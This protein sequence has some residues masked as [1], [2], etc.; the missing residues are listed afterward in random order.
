MSAASRRHSPGAIL[1]FVRY[2]AASSGRRFAIA[3]A[4]LV[5]G[6]LTEGVSILLVIPLLSLA[7]GNPGAG[8]ALP[9][10]MPGNLTL[11]LPEAL[12]GLVVLIALQGLFTRSKNIYLADLLFDLLN[13]LRLD[14]FAAIGALRWDALVR[15]RPSDLHHLLTGDVERVYT[16]AMAVMMLLQTA[17]LLVIYLAVAWI[18]S[19]VM[20]L[21][22]AALGLLILALLTPL[23]A[24]A[25]RFG[26]TRTANKRDQY[27][28]VSEYLG[29]LKT[30][31]IH[32]A[33]GAY[34]ARLAANLD[35]VHA[36]AVGYMRLISLGTILSQVVSAL[37]VAVL[38]YA[39]ISLLGMALP[40]LV[41][42]L[43]L[44]MRIAPRFTAMQT[45]L[46]QLLGEVTVFA[47]IQ[48]FRA[49]CAAEAEPPPPPPLALP[50]RLRDAI[51]LA[52]VRYA[53]EGGDARPAITD[54]DLSIP[55]G[56]ITA[57]VGPSGSG[58][59]TTADLVCG[60]L[61]PQAGTIHIDACALTPERARLW[62]RAIAYVPQEHFLIPG[63]IAANLRLARP[64]AGEGEMWRALERAGAADFVRALSHG[65]D[66]VLG[67]NG[68]RLSGGQRQRIALAR[69]L[70]MRP[71]LLVLDEATS[72]LDWESQA[73]FAR[74][75]AALR[76]R[77]TVLVIAHRL[78]MVAAAD[79]V[80]ALN[81]GRV[82][83]VGGF[84][85]LSRGAGPVSRLIA[86]ERSEVPAQP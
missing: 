12:A 16:A 38:V 33:E 42:F 71:Q 15:R 10:W 75:I 77:T 14:L 31:K 27:R 7:G 74:T 30:A 1:P 21:V 70:V 46:Q 32:G 64:E 68:A 11:G 48:H 61:T 58:K 53:Y 36:E 73:A 23:R 56:R 65:L 63:T 55:A 17:I 26:R 9:D 86:A 54:L 22:A 35:K 80:I 78:S 4:L 39:G 52:G 67:E 45:N 18:I 34:R 19:P 60:L 83:E 6:G 47:D 2:L 3:L 43:L 44:L 79:H 62:R 84:A 13:R 25:S 81:A 72:A 20:M 51:R 41:A 66:T 59:S 24:A 57:L 82:V 69:A 29:G 85:D 49:Q 5:L 8:F 37:A 50:P 40:Q 76:G 28:T